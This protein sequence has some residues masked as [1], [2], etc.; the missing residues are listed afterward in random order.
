MEQIMN[1]REIMKKFAVSALGGKKIPH[2][3]SNPVFRKSEDGEYNVCSFV[4]LYQAQELKDKSVRRPTKWMSINLKTGMV[5]EYN[6]SDLDFSSAPTETLC[7][8][9]ADDDTVFSTE[10]KQQTL[11]VFDLILKKFLITGRFDKELNDAYMY[12]M[13]RM[14]SVGFK[15]FYKE[16]NLV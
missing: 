3:V 16:L 2:G 8:L 14:V 13:L 10:Y 1:V 11:A 6:C 15:P 9:R 4:Y 7:D 5:T 12:M